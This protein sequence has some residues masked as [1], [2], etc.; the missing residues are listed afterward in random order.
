MNVAADTITGS[1]A[2]FGY[3]WDAFSEL[4]PEQEEQFRRWTVLLDPDDG[5]QGLRFLDVGCGAGRNSYWAMKYGAAS[6]TAIDVDETSLAAARRNLATWS[7]VDVSNQSAYEIAAEGEFDIAFSIGVIHHL[8]EPDRALRKMREAVKPGGRVLIWVYG[9]E[10]MERY[11]ALMDPLRRVLFRRLPMPVLQSLAHLPTALLWFLLRI[12]LNRLAYFRLLRQLPYR[13][14]HHILL[15]QM[16]PQIANYWTRD[17][18]QLLMEDAQLADINIAPV[19][20]MSW[21]A[22][23]VRPADD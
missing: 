11:L 6:G 23:G 12:G 4:T 7:D 16:L 18:V 22:V 14:L 5:W 19:N 20:D 9:R 15:D 3:S 1:S 10:N 2:R 17:E 13:H 8:A 21:C